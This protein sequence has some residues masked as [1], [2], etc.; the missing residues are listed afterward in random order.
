MPGQSPLA[1]AVPELG[2]VVD[3]VVVD[4]ATSGVV[5]D[6]AV[7][8]VVVGVVLPVVAAYAVVPPTSAPAIESIATVFF[9]WDFMVFTSRFLVCS[10]RSQ[11]PRRR[12]SVC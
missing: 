7:A 6:G 12:N 8:V 9:R 10:S 1:G 4:G 11:R 3:G 2:A 5:V